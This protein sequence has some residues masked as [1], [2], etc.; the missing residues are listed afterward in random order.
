MRRWL[1]IGAML[2]TLAWWVETLLPWPTLSA[3]LYVPSVLSLP[4][5]AVTALCWFW[6]TSP[7]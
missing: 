1:V 3:L 5:I 6:L 4:F 7:R 2:F